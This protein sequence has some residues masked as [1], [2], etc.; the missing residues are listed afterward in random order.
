MQK[1]KQKRKKQARLKYQ[2]TLRQYGFPFMNY[3]SM[4]N[5]VDRK[6]NGL[7]E[8]IRQN[9]LDE[10]RLIEMY[11]WSLSRTI[12]EHLYLKH[13]DAKQRL[14]LYEEK[15][16]PFIM[17]GEILA[18]RRFKKKYT[19]Q[20]RNQHGSLM[21]KTEERME[22]RV[23][24]YNPRILNMTKEEVL[25]KS[26]DKSFK[27]NNYAFIL[28]EGKVIDSHI[29]IPLNQLSV[30]GS[31]HFSFEN[32]TFFNVLL[33][34]T[35]VLE[36]HTDVYKG[37]VSKDVSLNVTKYG[38]RNLRLL[39]HFVSIFSPSENREVVTTISNDDSL[40]GNLLSP[41]V[42]AKIENTQLKVSPHHQLYYYYN[43]AKCMMKLPTEHKKGSR[44]WINLQS[45]Y[46]FCNRLSTLTGTIHPLALK[47]T[48]ISSAKTEKEKEKLK[49][50]VEKSESRQIASII[51]YIEEYM[52]EKMD[53]VKQLVYLVYGT[54]DEVERIRKK[55][56]NSY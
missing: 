25:A 38:V 29:W 55:Y 30:D 56:G 3:V 11:T 8:L 9:N 27:Q 4:E 21:L 44:E 19:R 13:T 5:F 16:K 53:E 22:S 15:D 10:M 34:E 54:G 42:F 40:T 24:L 7:R 46:L 43:E 37:K 52:P 12:I 45:K 26:N 32:Q 31:N 41:Y 35:L 51:D 14:R 39:D 20:Y 49:K 23:L 33:G 50:E 6:I 28:N 47:E 36:A 48:A 18:V 1:N 2:Q 17:A